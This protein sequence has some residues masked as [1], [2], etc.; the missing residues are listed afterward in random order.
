[1]KIRHRRKN[2]RSSWSSNNFEMIVWD[3]KNRSSESEYREYRWIRKQHCQS[4]FCGKLLPMTENGLCIINIRIHRSINI[5]EKIIPTE[6]SKSLSIYLSDVIKGVLFYELLQPDE[7]VPSSIIVIR[8]NNL[9]DKQK[10]LFIGRR[11]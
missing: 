10:R 8:L 6:H 11:N 2:S 1:M 5:N 7:T 3:R 4:S 9:V